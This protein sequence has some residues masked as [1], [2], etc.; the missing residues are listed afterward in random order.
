ML[1][2]PHLVI[3]ARDFIAACR[4]L[5]PALLEDLMPLSRALSFALNNTDV[6]LIESPPPGYTARV[7]AIY[8]AFIVGNQV[9]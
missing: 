4:L 1:S 2:A 7:R 5:A 3:L 8:D 6:D 9:Y